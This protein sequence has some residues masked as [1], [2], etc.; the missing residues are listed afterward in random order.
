MKI[1]IITINYN[2]AEGLLRTIDSVLKQTALRHIEYIVVDGASTDGSKDIIRAHADG[3]TYWTSEPDRGIY[4]AMNKGM[5]QASGDYILMLNSGDFL[6]AADTIERMLP[7]LES[8]EDFIVGEEMTYP[9]GEPTFT[10]TPKHI[11]LYSMYNGCSLPHNACFVKRSM[12]EQLRYDEKYRIV[13]DWKYFLEGIVFKGGSHK[14]VHQ[15]ITE[16]EVGGISSDK[17]LS[18]A[19]RESV[20]KEMLPKGI[21]DDY[22][23]FSRGALNSRT[24]YADFF[25][26]LWIKNRKVASL[27]YKFA[28]RISKIMARRHPSMRFADKFPSSH[29][30]ARIDK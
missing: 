14:V 29:P 30:E 21:L 23:S 9:D 12:A 8:G 10:K 13:S 2:N 5:A 4:H 3:I 22:Y 17:E 6:H 20:L 25:S 7:Q 18:F 26:E 11:T 28:V 16:F 15:T 1:S 24:R 27:F 19:E